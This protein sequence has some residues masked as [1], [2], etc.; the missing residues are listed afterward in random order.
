MSTRVALLWDPK[1]SLA[2]TRPTG[3]EL[4]K[5]SKVSS[6]VFGHGEFNSKLNFENV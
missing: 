3:L 2:A 1:A 5:F 6:T 4:P